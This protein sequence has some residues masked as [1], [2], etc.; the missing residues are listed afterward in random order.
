MGHPSSWR[1]Y[2]AHPALGL[3]ELEGELLLAPRGAELGVAWLA[4]P[5]DEQRRRLADLSAALRC[6]AADGW[7]VEIVEAGDR[8]GVRMDRWKAPALERLVLDR[9]WEA[10]ERR[11]EAGGRPV[12]RRRRDVDRLMR[13]HALIAWERH[14]WSA[15]VVGFALS[16]LLDGA[17]GTVA[18]LLA[19]AVAVVLFIGSGI[20]RWYR[21][22]LREPE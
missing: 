22:S 5:P 2:G 13:A 1:L 14:A 4:L 18:L 6:A 16:G 9:V 19:V 3:E 11:R 17:V 15:V 10:A 12:A 7:D 8:L 21:R 20:E